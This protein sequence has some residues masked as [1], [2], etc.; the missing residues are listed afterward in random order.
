M[1]TT[2]EE[3]APLNPSEEDGVV[4]INLAHPP[5]MEQDLGKP[6]CLC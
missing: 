3:R 2:D 6:S 4:T 1:A 5:E